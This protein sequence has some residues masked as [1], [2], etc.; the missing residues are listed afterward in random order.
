MKKVLSAGI[1]GLLMMGLASQASAS[2]EEGNFTMS[3]FETVNNQEMG[4][5]LGDQAQVISW[6]N[7]G[8][9]QVLA[10]GLDFTGWDIGTSGIGA[11]ASTSDSDNWMF[12]GYFASSNGALTSADMGAMT[13]AQLFH[14]ATISMN[15]LYDVY[16]DNN[17]GVAI[18]SATN[19]NGYIPKMN[20]TGPA[21]YGG[22]NLAS[23]EAVL[24]ADEDVMLYLYEFAPGDP[25]N[26]DMDPA[27]VGG[28]PV[29]TLTLNTAGEVV[30]NDVPLPAGVWLLGSGLVGLVGLRRRQS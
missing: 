29:A 17:D 25:A 2:F 28:G 10:S 6:I 16:D 7:A 3:V 8:E 5:D 12:S 4:I 15:Y 13:G 9:R 1:A 11:Y 14:G 20:Q 21:T 30:L 19:P 22:V 18:I 23:G 26:W 27:L 24:S